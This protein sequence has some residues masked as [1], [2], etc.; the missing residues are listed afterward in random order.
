MGYPLMMFTQFLD[1]L[2]PPSFPHLELIYTI[3]GMKF[4]QHLLLCALFHDPPKWTS[5]L[6]ASKRKRGTVSLP[7][8]K[9]GISDAISARRN[10]PHRI[11]RLSGNA[12]PA[13]QM[14]ENIIYGKPIILLV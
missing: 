4:M 1:F 11:I 12:K 13:L 2:T 14:S 8:A 7:A 5:Y 10:R 6:D 3:V 9:E